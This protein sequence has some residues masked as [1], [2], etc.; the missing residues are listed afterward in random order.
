MTRL[1]SIAA[2]AAAVLALAAPA[3]ADVKASR[4]GDVYRDS[5]TDAFTKDAYRLPPASSGWT[6]LRP[7][8]TKWSA[9]R[10][11]SNSWN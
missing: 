8:G 1:I 9:L 2:A 4:P 5:M 3:L 11:L 6:S 10:P 7:G